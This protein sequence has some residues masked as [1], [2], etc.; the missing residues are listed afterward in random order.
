MRAG[1]FDDAQTIMDEALRINPNWMNAHLC[2]GLTDILSGRIPEA[3]KGVEQIKRLDFKRR[4][5]ESSFCGIAYLYAGK[6]EEA[7]VAFRKA[8]EQVIDADFQEKIL[9]RFELGKMLALRGDVDGA[10]GAFSEANRVAAQAYHPSYNPAAVLSEYLFASAWIQNGD[11]S[12]A[13][14][15]AAH[16]RP[17]VESGDYEVIFKDFYHLLEAELHLNRGDVGASEQ[18][19][20]K[21][22]PVERKFS[23]RFHLLMGRMQAAKGNTSV[24]A[25]FYEDLCRNT[26]MSNHFLGGDTFDYFLECSMSDYYLGQLYENAGD[27]SR[28]VE[29]YENAL[30]RW[31]DADPDMPALLDT[32]AH[33]EK[34]KAGSE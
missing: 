28:A 30:D 33:L 22:G 32:K 2:K 5:W 20:A 25:R 12:R 1:R 16:I 11:D 23:P 3:V 17:I 19:L 34:L 21:V 9:A 18:E 31:K 15:H 4:S 7:T 27:P 29:Y 26:Y 24:A 10:Q 13:K 14:T 8:V 6:Y